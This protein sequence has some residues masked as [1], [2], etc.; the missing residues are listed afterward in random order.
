MNIFYVF[1]HH[2]KQ[3]SIQSFA[4]SLNMLRR[5]LHSHPVIIPKHIDVERSA[6][7]TEQNEICSI[8]SFFMALNSISLLTMF[9]PRLTSFLSGR[10]NKIKW[11]CER[12]KFLLS[13]HQMKEK[14]FKIQKILIFMFCLCESY[15]TS[16]VRKANWKAINALHFCIT[17]KMVLETLFCIFF[18][19]FMTTSECI[20]KN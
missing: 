14:M 5:C 7:P 17:I 8:E 6:F 15:L 3:F 18:L 12:H 9:S 16:F 11:I 2:K 4:F 20:A 13:L 1:T 10:K 19:L